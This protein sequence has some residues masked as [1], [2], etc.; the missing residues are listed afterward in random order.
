ME[1]KNTEDRIDELEKR[2]KSMQ[3]REYAIIGAVLLVEVGLLVLS[4]RI[5]G[6][7]GDL[8]KLSKPYLAK[9]RPE[10]N[11]DL[12]SYTKPSRSEAPVENVSRETIEKEVSDE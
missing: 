5:M 11:P 6:L 4:K 1:N 2:I 9:P 7:E 12:V 10:V 8:Y 3:T